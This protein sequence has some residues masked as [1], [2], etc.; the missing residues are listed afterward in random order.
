M[1]D[2]FSVQGSPVSGAN[3][4]NQGGITIYYN[5]SCYT[6]VIR[7]TSTGDDYLHI[8]TAQV[9]GG[10]GTGVNIGRPIRIT[11]LN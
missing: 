8:N 7:R 4:T 1:I 3:I 11:G 2:T 10:A 6:R 9:L 5:G